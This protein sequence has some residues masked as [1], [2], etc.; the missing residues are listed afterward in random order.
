M[1]PL[2]HLLL[3][4]ALAAPAA[5]FAQTMPIQKPTPPEPAHRFDP[6][7][8]APFQA[9]VPFTVP[10]IDNAPDLYGDVVDPQL[11][12]FFGGNQFM[13]LDD[14]LKEF[15]KAH[16]EYVRIF[17]ET[18]PPGILAKQITQGSLVVGNLRIE[19]KPLRRQH[20]CACGRSHREDCRPAVPAYQ[21]VLCLPLRRRCDLRR[22]G[23]CRACR[24]RAAPRSTGVHGEECRHR[25]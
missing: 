2:P 5:L 13:V 16:P 1:K 14:L 4:L 7:W 19:L 12:V 25:Q 20:P 11:V 6:P 10:G 18:L 9:G 8:N 15:R 17:V 3:A 22:R 24:R 21:R 23:A